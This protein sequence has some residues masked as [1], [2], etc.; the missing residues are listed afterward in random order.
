MKHESIFRKARQEVME[1]I[2]KCEQIKTDLHSTSAGM[3][4]LKVE[5]AAYELDLAVAFIDEA[6]GEQ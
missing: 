2:K 3:A 6:L 5:E 4:A 1:I